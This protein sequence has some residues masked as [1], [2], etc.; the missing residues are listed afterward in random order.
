MRL[1]TSVIDPGEFSFTGFAID[2]LIPKMIVTGDEFILEERARSPRRRW[3][4]ALRREGYH[5]DEEGASVGKSRM[6]MRRG[7]F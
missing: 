1:M 3:R 4:T 5:D 6:Y 2:G 7:R